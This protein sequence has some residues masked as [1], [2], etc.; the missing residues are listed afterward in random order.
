MYVEYIGTYIFQKQF[1]EF[2]PL[3]YSLF[4][5]TEQQNFTEGSQFILNGYICINDVFF[6]KNMYAWTTS[7]GNI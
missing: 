7:S 2:F 4:F 1:S 5:K 6:I 3:N